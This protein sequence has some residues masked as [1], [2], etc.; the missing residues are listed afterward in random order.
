MP[1]RLYQAGE[2]VYVRATIL[3]AQ[4][5]AFQIRIE[6]FPRVSITAWAPPSEVARFEDIGLLKP[7]RARADCL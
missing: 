4:S 7:R 2:T 1:S 5:D 3:V 6:D